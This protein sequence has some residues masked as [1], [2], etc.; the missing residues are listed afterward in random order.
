[1]S[2]NNLNVVQNSDIPSFISE[3]FKSDDVYNRFM[4]IY[5]ILV[6]DYISKKSDFKSTDIVKSAENESFWMVD[7]VSDDEILQIHS[8]QGYFRGLA[9]TRS[10]GYALT[11]SSLTDMIMDLSLSKIDYE[12]N[13]LIDL[14]IGHYDCIYGSVGKI[15]FTEEEKLFIF[16]FVNG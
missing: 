15:G 8:R 11:L 6:E 4:D 9:T 12:R 13:E 3:V 5:N 10:I 14:F 7:V 2:D 16:D 1:M